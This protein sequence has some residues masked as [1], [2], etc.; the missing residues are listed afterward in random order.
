MSVPSHRSWPFPSQGPRDGMASRGREGESPEEAAANP[1]LN[2]EV[3]A[4]GYFTTLGVPV[5]GPHLTDQDREDAP[6]VVV[7]SQ[8]A[9][10][11]YWPGDDPIGKRLMMGD[12]LERVFTVIGVV[13]DTRYRDLR[14]ARPSIYFPLSQSFF[15]FVPTTLAKFERIAL[16]LAGIHYPAGHQR[17]GTRRSP[18]QRR[19]VRYVPRGTAGPAE[20][21]RFPSGRVRGRSI[22]VSICRPVRGHGDHD[23][24]AHQRARHSARL[25]SLTTGSGADG[26]APRAHDRDGRTWSSVFWVHFSQTDS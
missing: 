21:E 1:M 11:H 7:V 14:E 13:P 17:D 15:P 12:D 23:P 22:D 8:S 26:N 9:A 20:N 2:M 16:P 3:V 24:P 25:R 10:R 6:P 19:V 4:P 5:P 18:G